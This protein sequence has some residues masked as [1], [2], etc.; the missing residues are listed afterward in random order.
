MLSRIIFIIYLV[1]MKVFREWGVPIKSRCENPEKWAVEQMIELS[2]LPFTFR[3][4]AIMPDTH[5]G[6]WMPIWWVLATKW[7]VIP[8]LLV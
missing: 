1:K 8:M 3:H 4:V 7:V 6:Y 5:Q 2:K